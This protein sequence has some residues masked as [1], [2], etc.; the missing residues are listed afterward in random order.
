MIVPKPHILSIHPTM[1]C[2]YH[3]FGCY[4]KRDEEAGRKEKTPEFFVDLLKA[5]SRIGIKEIAIPAN[6]HNTD[7][8]KTDLNLIY[9]SLLKE[10]AALLKMEFTCTANYDF[11]KN[12]ID[13]YPKL[14][15]DVALMS[16]SINDY[17]T[18]TPEKKQE[19]LQ[20][21]SRIK[22]KVPTVNCNILVSPNMVKLLKAGL[23]KEILDRVDTVY[24]LVQKPLVV[25]M[26]T[27]KEWLSGLEEFFDMI[28]DRVILDSC[29]K[30]AFGLTDGICSKHQLIY[31]NPYGDV[32]HCSYDGKTMFKLD[33]GDDL[34][35]LFSDH[36]P[37]RQ[38][39]DCRLLHYAKEENQ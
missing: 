10:W 2:D 23:M 21:L 35:T 18:S 28:D 27:I 19:A 38:L 6:Y 16:V 30:S 8:G 7:N 15:Y 20:M 34:Q 31:V 29:L 9:Y 14:L 32:K 24:L 25:P 11:L 37:Q 39:F 4:L 17:S 26:D 3:C 22:E 13:K 36:Y 12:Y 1:Q 33:K 5:A